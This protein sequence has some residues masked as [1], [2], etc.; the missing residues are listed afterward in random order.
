MIVTLR[1]IHRQAEERFVGML[2]RIVEPGCSI[3]QIVVASQKSGRSQTALIRRVQLVRRQHLDDHA[4]V[5][6]IVV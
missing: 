6:F 4:I 1:A 2:D 3:E 5:A